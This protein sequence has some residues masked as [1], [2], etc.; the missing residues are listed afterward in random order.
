MPAVSRIVTIA[1]FFAGSLARVVRAA[2][3][4][5]ATSARNRRRVERIERALGRNVDHRVCDSIEDLPKVVDDLLRARVELLGVNGGDGTIHSVLT[6]LAQKC[7]GDFPTLALLPGGSTNMTARDINAGPL[8]LRAAL[9]SFVAAIERPP[10]TVS[11]CAI[12]ARDG[13]RPPQIGFLFGM[14]AV[15][16][17]I[18]YCHERIFALGIRK[19]L[20]SGIAMARAAWGIARRE[21]VFAQGVALDARFDGEAHR[22]RASIFLVTAL[23]ALFL[24]IKPFWGPGEGPLAVTWVADDARRFLR[25]FPA[26]LRGEADRLHECEGYLSR[27]AHRVEVRGDDRYTIDGEIYRAQGDLVLDDYRPLSF[28]PLGAAR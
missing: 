12:R 26:L 20:A 10:K 17:G 7:E 15:I 18:E 2:V 13:S 23:D 22:G 9:A 4:T 19:E 28:V 14:G 1:R 27:R 25:T 21:P 24:G 16:R 6:D 3:I 5:N 11:R 8:S